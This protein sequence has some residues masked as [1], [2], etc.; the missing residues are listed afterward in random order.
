MSLVEQAGIRLYE[1]VA[2]LSLKYLRPFSASEE[3][4]IDFCFVCGANARMRFNPWSIHKDTLKSWVSEIVQVE[5]L[6]RESL[7]CAKCSAS[8]RV[9]NIARVILED[10]SSARISTFRDLVKTDDFMSKRILQVN[11]VGGVGSFQRY[12]GNCDNVT[13]T[14]Y[15]ERIPFGQSKGARLNQDV[16]NLQFADNSFDLILHSDVLEHVPDFK[17]AHKEILRVL[18]PGGSVI[19]TI[20]IQNSYDKSWSR[21]SFSSTDATWHFTK[22][23]VWHGRAGGPF[24]LIPR[25]DD[26]LEMHIFGRDFESL[27]AQE[28]VSVTK[29]TCFPPWESGADI[30]FKARK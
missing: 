13:T 25:R 26:Y 28:N 30:V 12:L 1:F 18:K 14:F 8:F 15:S 27:I 19:F 17:R 7:F 3:D 22:A 9:R 2:Q 29:A 10:F 6:R 20:P 11:S 5:Y 23:K 4:C 16:T 21:I 24:S